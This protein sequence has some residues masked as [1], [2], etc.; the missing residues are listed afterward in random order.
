MKGNY[1]GLARGV[2]Q[3]QLAME[4]LRRSDRVYAAEIIASQA[5]IVRRYHPDYVYPIFDRVFREFLEESDEAGGLLDRC[6]PVYFMHS[7]RSDFS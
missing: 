2:Q 1:P 3:Q 7:Y 4:R 5:E 6:G